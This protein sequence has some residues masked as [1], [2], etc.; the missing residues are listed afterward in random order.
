MTKLLI[1]DDEPY[2]VEMLQTY[3]KLHGFETFGALCGE[4]A[5]V[6]VKVEHPEIVILDL[7]LPDVE[8]YE[9][10]RR[11]R[12]FPETAT[13]PVLILSARGDA[14]SKERALAAGANAYLVKPARFPVLLETLQRLLAS[15]AHEPKSES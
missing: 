6:L 8:G 13:L 2:T 3:L 9:V 4:D 5:L 15:P 14:E 12:S 7:M 10:C 1:V 11:I